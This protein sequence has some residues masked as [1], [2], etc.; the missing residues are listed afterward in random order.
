LKSNILGTCAVVLLI[1]AFFVARILHQPLLYVTCCVSA[2]VCSVVAGARGGKGW[3][4]VSLVSGLLSAQAIFA[5]FV[6]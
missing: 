3:L 6:E 1:G 2:F 5:G 4:F